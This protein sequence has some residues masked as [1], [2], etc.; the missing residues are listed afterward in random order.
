[1]PAFQYRHA[2]LH[3]AAFS[4][5]R[6]SHSSIPVVSLKLI[7]KLLWASNAGSSAGRSIDRRRR[8]R[9][10]E[11][12]AALACPIVFAR[13]C[14]EQ[15]H[16]IIRGCLSTNAVSRHKCSRATKCVHRRRCE[17]GD[18]GPAQR[19]RELIAHLASQCPR[20]SEPQMVGVRG[21]ASADQTRLSG[22]EL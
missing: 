11:R 2:A 19:H 6:F 1:M 21:A 17:S 22:N 13:S 14:V 18:V 3:C 12:S 10:P 20:L 4:F 5:C 16:H 15:G 8:E 9:L 7:L